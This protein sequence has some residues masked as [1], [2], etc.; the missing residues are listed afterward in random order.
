MM[1]GIFLFDGW[2]GFSPFQIDFEKQVSFTNRSL[3]METD[4]TIKPYLS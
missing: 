4:Y 2:N 3:L 1:P